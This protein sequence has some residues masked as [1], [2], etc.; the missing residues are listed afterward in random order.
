MIAIILSVIAMF[1]LAFIPNFV[2]PEISE[3]NINL[4]Y[5][6]FA[7]VFILAAFTDFLDGHIARKYNLVTTFGKFLDPIADKLLNDAMMIFL[8]VPQS[9]ALMQ[10]KD[11]MMLTILMICVIFM[12]ARDLLVDGM[13]L[14]ASQKGKVVAANIFGKFK[15]VLQMISIPFLLLNDWP[16]SYFDNFLPE[17][18]QIS[19]LLFYLATLMS[20]ISGI[21]Y[22]V[23]NRFVF[24]DN[25]DKAVEKGNLDEKNLELTSEISSITNDKIQAKHLLETLYEKGLTLGSTESITGGKFS[26][27]ITSVPGASKVF[28]GSLVT[29]TPEEKHNLAD[30]NTETINKFGVVSEETSFEMAKGGQKRLN[31]DVCVS[32]TGNAGPTSDVDNKPVGEVHISVAYLSNVTYAKYSLNGSREYIQSM[33]VRK[34]I[35]LVLFSL[36][37]QR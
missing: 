25:K 1:V 36:N 23:Q 22:L 28:K 24:K 29:Y 26:A 11:E 4:V 37:N 19:N 30:V 18:L 10:R 5:L 20:L 27:L 32:V 16:F 7:I 2:A 12:I 17:Y 14:V 8:L 9:Y 6:I 34:M 3:T 21:I 35:E 31:V 33:C 13:R 15:T